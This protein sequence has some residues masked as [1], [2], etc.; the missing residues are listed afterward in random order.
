MY[1]YDKKIFELELSNGFELK[2][3]DISFVNIFHTLKKGKNIINKKFS[4][5]EDY[6]NKAYDLI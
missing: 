3:S 4:D 5:Y 1:W 6:K 2:G